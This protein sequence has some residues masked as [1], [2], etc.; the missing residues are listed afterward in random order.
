MFGIFKSCTAFSLQLLL[1]VKSI[2]NQH[3]EFKSG[4][5]LKKLDVIKCEG[6]CIFPDT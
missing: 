3:V 6:H 2:D 4:K 1:L 5:I